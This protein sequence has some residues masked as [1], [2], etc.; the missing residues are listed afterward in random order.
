MK[1]VSFILVVIVTLHAQCG[2]SCLGYTKLEPECHEHEESQDG[3]NSCRD[4]VQLDSKEISK[5]RLSLNSAMVPPAPI[6]ADEI[7][8]LTSTASPLYTP[9]NKRS[10]PTSQILVL[11]I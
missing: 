5:F 3:S 2:A 8:T 4:A 9:P 1:I 11:R 6:S 10:F 7:R